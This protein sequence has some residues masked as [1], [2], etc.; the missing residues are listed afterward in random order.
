VSA[1]AVP[2]ATVAGRLRLHGRG[3]TAVRDR[4]LSQAC[5]LVPRILAAAAPDLPEGAGGWTIDRAFLTS[6]RMAIVMLV[7]GDGVTGA[8]VKLPTTPEA[9]EALGRESGTLA[10]LGADVRLGDWRALVPQPCAFGEL[11]GQPYR[12]D[13]ALP[14]QSVVDTARDHAAIARAQWQ[15]AAQIDGLHRATAARVVVDERLAAQWIDAP[16][17]SA[18]GRAWLTHSAAD[19]LEALRRELHEALEGRELFASWVHGDYWLGNVLFAPD[20]EEVE[21]IVDWDAAARVDLPVH[22]VLHLLLYGRRLRT[23]KEL[24]GIIER[25]LA[26]EQWSRE[27]REMLDRYGS[28]SHG[29]VLS[30]RHVLLLYWLRHVGLHLSQQGASGGMRR[31]LWETRNV[32]CVLGAL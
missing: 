6:T 20:G 17:V 12:I 24:G 15:A 31:R 4:A 14:G 27:E 5:A 29:G 21:G 16:L 18:F 30:D 10:E 25:R 11:L 7:R 22:D 2:V 23:G 8:V 9:A 32:H 13:C 19:Q 1:A 28:W 26:G 3:G